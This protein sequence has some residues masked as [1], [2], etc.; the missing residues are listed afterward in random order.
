[1]NGIQ[2]LL[3]ED[4]FMLLSE[5]Q[6]SVGCKMDDT[7][8]MVSFFELYG[9]FVQDLL[10]DGKRLKVLEDGKGE[11]VVTGLYELEAKD[12]DSLKAI[13]ESGNSARTTHTTEAN[14]TSSR[15]HA[16]C[17]ITLRGRNSKA[18]RGKLSLVDLAGSE[19]GTDTKSHNLQ[20][21]AE[22]ADINT[23]LLALKECIR[24]LDM[25][26]KGPKHVPYRASKLTLILKD[27]FTSDCAMTTMIATASP[28]ASAADHSLNT[29]R[30]AD[31]IKEK[32]IPGQ[33]T[34]KTPSRGHVS[35]GSRS[36]AVPPVLNVPKK[37]SSPNDI[38]GSSEEV[39]GAPVQSFSRRQSEQAL[40][41]IGE[42][43]VV[44]DDDSENA[45]ANQAEDILN[46]HMENIQENAELLAEEGQLLQL[47]QQENVA[48]EEMDAYVAALEKIL[49]R[50]ED[51][52]LDLRAKIGILQARK[53]M[54]DDGYE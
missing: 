7:A 12:V 34:K 51:M 32:R 30:Y 24:A 14:D 16:I 23:S 48:E 19:R 21:R 52:I 2:E 11:V 8:V 54:N 3:C 18:L 44:E 1:M 26:K 10:N 4:L 28:G 29:L 40:G 31:R 47:V 13:L 33:I 27:C 53:A 38:L 39:D 20:R 17:Q 37:A 45:F 41:S 9:G 49:E 6:Q 5:P 43:F 50:K 36:R 35:T 25:N 15:S 46:K 42:D 22:S